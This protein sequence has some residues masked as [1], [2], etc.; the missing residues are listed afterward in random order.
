MAPQTTLANFRKKETIE[1]E[2]FFL[3]IRRGKKID[4]IKNNVSRK[5]GVTLK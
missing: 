5:V 4:T 1:R 2:V 3:R